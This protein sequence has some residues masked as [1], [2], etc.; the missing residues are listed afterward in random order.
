MLS[1]ERYAQ[2][3]SELAFLNVHLVTTLKEYERVLYYPQAYEALAPLSPPATWVPVP[4]YQPGTVVPR[5]V[6]VGAAQ[7]AASWPGACVVARQALHADRRLMLF[8]PDAEPVVDWV[9][10]RDGGQR[11]PLVVR[12]ANLEDVFLRV[13]GAQLEGGA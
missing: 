6:F 9:R 10:A 4:Q 1:A 12:P 7:E 5:S 8:A 11:R 3:H 13:S 2:L